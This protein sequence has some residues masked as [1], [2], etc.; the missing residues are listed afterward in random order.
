[1]VQTPPQNGRQSLAKEDLPVDTAGQEQKRKT[2]TIMEEQS[3]VLHEK[4]KPGRRC[5][6]GQTYLAFVSEQ[7]VFCC[8]D[9]SN[10][11]NDKSVV[12][13]ARAPTRRVVSSPDTFFSEARVTLCP[14]LEDKMPAS[15]IFVN[16]V[17]SLQLSSPSNQLKSFSIFFFRST[18][19]SF[20]FESNITLDI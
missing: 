13:G 19:C 10:N 12:W 16:T 2:G 3:D 18:Y 15:V 8:I 14:R 9:L 17:F 20:S 4:Q 5:G 1:M 7:T 6:R 11:K